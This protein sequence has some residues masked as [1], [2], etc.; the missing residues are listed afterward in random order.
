MLGWRP[1]IHE[2][3]DGIWPRF[4]NLEYGLLLSRNES[5]LWQQAETLITLN[6]MRGE[7]VHFTAAHH[8]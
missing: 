4:A 3:C 7:L 8:G 6:A 5:A 2:G 1:A